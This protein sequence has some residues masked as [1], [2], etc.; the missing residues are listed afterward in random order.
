LLIT[1]EPPKRA[2]DRQKPT[3]NTCIGMAEHLLA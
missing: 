3:P 2:E 1:G